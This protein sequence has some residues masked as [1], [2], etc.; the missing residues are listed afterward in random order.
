[1]CVCVKAACTKK[2]TH[3]SWQ[4]YFMCLDKCCDHSVHA[5]MSKV[6]IANGFGLSS[7]NV[8]KNA[9]I[10]PGVASWQTQ[11]A[12]KAVGWGSR[13]NCFVFSSK[14]IRLS[15]ASLMSATKIPGEWLFWIQACMPF[16]LS[17][18]KR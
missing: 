4:F 13:T 16:A 5:V 11:P 18:L 8:K 1:M 3:Q 12:I 15:A 6:S 14:T 9:K 2:T 7:T 10:L 17:Q